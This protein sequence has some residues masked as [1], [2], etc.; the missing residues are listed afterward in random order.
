MTSPMER[1]NPDALLAQVHA[2]ERQRTRGKLKVFFGASPGVGKTYAMLQAA[3]E[4]RAKGVDVVVGLVE[5]HGRRD[6]ARLLEGL[7]QLP[8]REVEYRGRVLK[9]FDLEVA[10]ARQPGLLLVDEL[11]HTNVAGSRHPKRYQDVEELLDAGVDIYTTVNVQHLESLNDVVG[12]ITGARVWE[13]VPDSVF[14]SANAVVLVDLP[15]DELLARLQAGKVYIPHQAERAM[16]NFFRKGNLMALREMALRRTADRVDDDV[17][18]WRRQQAVQTVWPMRESLLVCVRPGAGSERLVRSA[19]RLAG[20]LQVPWHALYVETPRLQR[21][22]ETERTRVLR[23]LQLA[24]QLGAQTANRP[25]DDTVD[26]VADYAREHNLGKVLLG[27][28]QEGTGWWALWQRLRPGLA[29]RLLRRAPD[30]DVV[31][32]AT[33]G[34][35]GERAVP[36]AAGAAVPSGRSSQLPAAH[37]HAAL[38]VTGVTLLAYLLRNYLDQANIVMLFLLVVLF[39]AVRLGRNPAVLAA[40]LS[41]ASFDFFFVNPIMSFSVSDVQYLLTFAVMLTVALITAH[42]TSGLR[43]QRD[44]A[45]GRERRAA[46]LYEMARE[47]SAAMSEDQIRDIA[48]RF[49]QQSFQAQAVLLPLGLADKL[50]PPAQLPA[51]MALD[52]GLAQWT[53]EH[54]EAAGLSTDTLPSSPLLYLPLVAPMRTRGVL[55][56]RPSHT[57]WLPTPEQQRLLQTAANLVAIALERVHYNEVAQQALLQM[58]SEQL[59]NNLLAAVS[60]DLRTPLTALVGL[61]DALE[62]Q[63]PPLS[64]GQHELVQA[65]RAEAQRTSSLV[66]NLLDM[67]RLQSGAVTLRKEWQ[68]VEEVIGT[69]LKA[70]SAALAQHQVQI[71]IPPELPLVEWDAVLMERALCNLLENAAKY[72]P[73]GSHIEIRARTEGDS[74]R[75]CVCDD[76]PGLPQG[77]EKAVFDK[78][79]RGKDES[80]IPGV[81]LGL[82]IVRAVVEAHQGRVWAEP[83][84]QGGSCFIMSLPLGTAPTVPEE[85]P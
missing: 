73:E 48:A 53:L 42:L 33:A 14:D 10:L 9:E 32:L 75:L 17:Q 77:K 12:R 56:L 65:I 35:D 22:P 78:F 47:L 29:Q 52:L 7:E 5:T 26:V 36:A 44:V 46:A 61:S 16:Q 31:Q 23:T 82:A 67:A 18:A 19:A 4:Q 74:L 41:V 39:A 70:R 68:P 85:S 54:A 11:A 2:E 66:H 38:G 63:G 34:V 72:T 45:Q 84:A 3:Q 51:D 21:L 30:L 8:L 50:Q 24:Q 6:T 57:P 83:R 60:H 37:L 28:E 55:A 69:A 76:G 25:G 13:T 80:A 64:T 49:A 1:P 58:Q 43:F 62:L 27:R 40:V 81:G 71:D 79:T 59:R 15:P 20:Q